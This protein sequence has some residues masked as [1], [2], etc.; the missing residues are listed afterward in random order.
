M[1]IP[2]KEELAKLYVEERLSTTKIAKLFNVSR[3]TI[4]NHLK[5]HG[6]VVR[7]G[8]EA[9]L[10]GKT[11][12]SKNE[13]NDLY[14]T[15]HMSM[16]KIGAIYNV[17]AHTIR[18]L[19]K[20]YNISIRTGANAHLKGKTLPTKDEL[21][22]LYITQRL[23]I[24]KI[25]DIYN[26]SAQTIHTYLKKHDIKPRNPSEAR[27]K[28][29]TLPTKESLEQLYITQMLTT[30]EIANMYNVGSSTISSLLKKYDIKTRDSSSA[31]LKGKSL[32][33]K[34]ELEYLY[35]DKKLTPQEI[36]DRYGVSV[37]VIRKY[38]KKYNIPSRSISQAHLKGK[39]LPSIMELENL[40]VKERLSGAEIAKIYGVNE[41][42][43]HRYLKRCGIGVRSFNISTI[44]HRISDFINSVNVNFIQTA[45]TIINPYELD[46]YIPSH[47]FA[48]EFNGVYWHSEQYR[49]K[50]YHHKKYALCKEKG[51]FLF[52]IWEDDYNRNPELV[53]RMI[54]HKL[55]VSKEQRV[56]ARKCEIKQIA[57]YQARCFYE[58]NHLQ[59]FVSATHHIGLFHDNELVAACSFKNTQ[60]GTDLVRFATACHVIGGFT[61][62]LKYFVKTYQPSNL[63]TFSDNCYSDGSLYENNGFVI[64]KI[65]S[66][67]YK[68]VVNNQREH[69]FKYRIKRFKTD[70]ELIYEDGL[71]EKQLAELNGLV[72]IWD[73][74]KVKWKFIH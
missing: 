45:R 50:D 39:T 24:A 60:Y 27:L 43:I 18:R 53:H 42:T 64:D 41:S 17:D 67:D 69:K 54:A 13:L 59:G 22:Q 74:G 33:T 57:T 21:T 68:Y 12:P 23:S 3:Q 34:K 37:S 19:L 15:K 14:T 71:T 38:V 63:Y 46:I 56:Y 62:L 70:P 49:D 48:I 26:V 29:K 31:K 7:S 73:A 8:T 6:I 61:K 5:K 36:A 1:R 10:N 20:K 32:P 30:K 72:R 65:L 9:Q 58:Q 40:Y 35:I 2:S 11:I 66:P 52:Q 25:S 28:G 16:S 55:G 44:E 4:S 47:K 51:I